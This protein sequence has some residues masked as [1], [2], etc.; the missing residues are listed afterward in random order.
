MSKKNILQF[1]EAGRTRPGQKVKFRFRRS[2]WWKV[3]STSEDLTVLR[4]GNHTTRCTP[5]YP[6]LQEPFDNLSGRL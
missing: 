1:V 6:L 5:G 4:R 2:G 3:E